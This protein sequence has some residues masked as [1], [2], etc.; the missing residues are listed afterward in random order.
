M[1]QSRNHTYEQDGKEVLT[2]KDTKT[3]YSGE[4]KLRVIQFRQ[5]NQ[6]S[7]RETTNHFEINLGSTITSWKHICSN[8][9]LKD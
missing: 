4:F 3:E 5:V 7:Y 6:L 9:D 8:N 1:I 2:Q